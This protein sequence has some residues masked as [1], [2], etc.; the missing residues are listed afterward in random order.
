MADNAGAPEHHPYK[1]TSQEKTQTFTPDGR[2]VMVWRVGYESLTSHNH[3]FV[4]IPDSEYDPAHV[5]QVIQT[6]LDT[7]E[8]VH[9]LGPE[10]HPENLAEGASEE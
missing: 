8:G 3:A 2:F 9:E 10:P 1:I 5:D 7:I 6:E 4:E